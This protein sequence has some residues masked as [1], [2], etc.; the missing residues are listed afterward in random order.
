MTREEL[1]I[2]LQQGLAEI[3]AGSA[4]ELAAAH[5]EVKRWKDEWQ[6]L[7]EYVSNIR[8]SRIWADQAYFK[9]KQEA[10]DLAKRA[11][12]LERENGQL[13]ELI[14]ANTIQIALLERKVE[15]LTKGAA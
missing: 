10:S 11:E 3:E 8:E 5:N 4:G 7:M 9:A 13:R 14:G 1:K 2:V 6:S 12:E 15:R